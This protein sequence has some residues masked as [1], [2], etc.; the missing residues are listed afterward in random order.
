MPMNIMRFMLYWLLTAMAT[1]LWA[2]NI[3]DSPVAVSKEQLDTAMAEVES[4]SG[5]I[6][7]KRK[8][9]LATYKEAQDWLARENKY[10]DKTR[11][12]LAS[13]TEAPR[14]SETLQ[15]KLKTQQSKKLDVAPLKKKNLE[16]LEQLL[17]TEKA[18]YTA[19][20]T[21]VE[22]LSQ[23]VADETGRPDAARAELA[24]TTR[25]LDELKQGFPTE[26]PS[27]PAA[28]AQWWRD[29]AMMQALK[30]KADMLEQEILSQPARLKLLRAQLDL[31]REDADGLSRRINAL[32]DLINQRRKEEAEQ[33]SRSE[34]AAELKVA[35]QYPALKS[36]AR[37]NAILGEELKEMTQTL[38]EA[39][40][41]DNGLQAKI[42]QLEEEYL[43]TQ[44]KVE[45]AGLRE[46]LGQVLLERRK[47]LPDPRSYRK[48]EAR[49]RKEITETGLRLIRHKEKLRKLESQPPSPEK[50][51]PGL[52][53]QEKKALEK[54]Y[55]ELLER[56]KALL[57]RILATDEAYLR[58]LSEHGVLLRRALA[59]L[60][61][62]D[63]FLA[64]H[65]L[66]VRNTPVISL[67]DLKKIPGELK[68]LM[69]VQA[70]VHMWRALVQQLAKPDSALLLLLLVLVY[71][72][73]RRWLKKALKAAMPR[74]VKPTSGSFSATLKALLISFL[75]PVPFILLLVFATWQLT[76]VSS[77]VPEYAD[78]LVRALRQITLPLYS[79]LVMR[80]MIRPQGLLDQHFHWR[81]NSVNRLRRAVNWLLLTFV[82]SNVLAML[83][84]NLTAEGLASV[85]LKLVF[86]AA[87]LS[88]GVFIYMV[89]QPYRGTVASFLERNS[90]GVLYRFRWLWFS[91]L[92]SVPLGLMVLSF[93][94]YVY[95]AGTLL[96]YLINSL[97]LLAGLILVQQLTEHWLL[98]SRR[99]I[100]Y[101]AA[102]ER[103][104]AMQARKDG[105]EAVPESMDGD[106]PEPKVDLVALSK[107]SRK[108]LNAA[109]LIAG[110]V[111]IWLIWSQVMPALSI[112]DTV[113][114]W[115]RSLT[116]DGVVTKVPVTLGDVMLV[117]AIAVATWVAARNLPS[118]L[119]II[120][121]QYFSISA[122][123]RYAART[124][125]G[126]V[127]V[128]T[129]L[130]LVF[131]A[132]GG[133]WA[134][135]Q[136]LVAA[137]SVGIG[138]G[139]Q[140]I[141]ANFIS[142]LII[143]FER[144]IR[145]GD[146][147][148]VGDTDGTVTRIQIR[149][150]TILTR[151]RK[152]LLVPNKEFITGRLLNWSLSDQTTRLKLVVGIPYGANVKLA[153]KLMLQAAQEHPRVQ[154]EPR[155]FVYFESFGDSALILELRCVI[156]NVDYRVVTLSELHH[157]IDEKFREAGMEIPFPQQDVHLDVH[158]PLEVKLQ[159]E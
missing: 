34:D 72:G 37:D 43:S 11:E 67:G 69:D 128:A 142:G 57:H 156:D 83:I 109:M 154:K 39:S 137:L 4:S 3:S 105:G 88:L 45:I 80:A 79:L 82:P 56:K 59:K 110:A 26:I 96:N 86:A 28:Q 130:V 77:D 76:L 90:R 81:K 157:A 101:Q 94:G 111:G 60:R 153:E 145:V 23:A 147:V 53:D 70:W 122:G 42:K 62:Y 18:A 124:L 50:L 32:E 25:Q 159:P 116:V 98:L 46:A 95:T 136:W 113:P 64:G 107:E 133:D 61:A 20:E 117:V 135:I 29:K 99:R 74:S 75:L 151:D 40:K 30:A 24:D 134:Q 5:L 7:E 2:E 131:K 125:T 106:V 52:S 114:L 103:R 78:A 150:T 104:K 144:P 97:W 48:K 36:L 85:T 152:E 1:T 100:A 21:R 54:P 127:I 139:L 14:Q 73:G 44:R 33:V 120:L 146:Y 141:V 38:E 123:S 17:E 51:A 58:V 22:S 10:R 27:D 93:L 68:E 9:I 66:W 102:L 31:A 119:E 8:N 138:F 19:K 65:L 126:Y 149:A 143:L 71:A 91:L 148:T 158:G 132:M 84:V 16:E 121:L 92:L 108:L 47:S 49:I 115:Q 89:F 55:R 87:I 6:D 112:L 12:Y 129:G 41:R 118:L 140:E 35:Q 155:P 63:D 13:R 15:R